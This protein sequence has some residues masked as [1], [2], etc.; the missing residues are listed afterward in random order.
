MSNDTADLIDGAGTTVA[1]STT[2]NGL[3]VI[4]GG[5]GPSVRLD[6]NIVKDRIMNILRDMDVKH[7]EEVA[8]LLLATY[9]RASREQ[10]KMIALTVVAVVSIQWV[11]FCLIYH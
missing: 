4:P 1:T 2:R 8:E 3:R 6:E 10:W 9:K 11:I 7:R 5:R